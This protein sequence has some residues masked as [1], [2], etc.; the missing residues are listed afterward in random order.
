M[1]L[2][3]QSREMRRMTSEE[4]TC[5]IIIDPAVNDRIAEHF[6]F[7]V[8]VSENAANKLLD[9]QETEQFS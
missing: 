8:R 1:P 9:G 4:T 5:Q 7:L 6:K 2:R 3:K